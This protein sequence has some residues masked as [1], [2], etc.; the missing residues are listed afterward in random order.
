[1][2]GR[3]YKRRDT[4]EDAARVRAATRAIAKPFV[5]FVTKRAELIEGVVTDAF[6]DFV[7]MMEDGKSSHF[8]LTFEDGRVAMIDKVEVSSMVIRPADEPQLALPL[9][10]KDA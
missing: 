4:S 3:D 2:S 1:M 7:A 10:R 5:R 9:E 6:G 8:V